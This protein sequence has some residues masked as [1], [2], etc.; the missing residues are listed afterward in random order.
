V[1]LLGRERTLARVDTTLDKFRA[2]A[3]SENP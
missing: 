3:Q 2:Q 1:N